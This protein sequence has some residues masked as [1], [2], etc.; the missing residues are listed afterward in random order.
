MDCQR[1]G[2]LVIVYN[3]MHD[4]IIG[5]MI[6]LLR[7]AHMQTTYVTELQRLVTAAD[8]HLSVCSN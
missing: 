7:M 6:L 5:P 4:D 8:K 1:R 3:A 2:R